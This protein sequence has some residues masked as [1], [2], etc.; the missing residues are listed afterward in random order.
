MR[1]ACHLCL[2]SVDL[3]IWT[4][5]Q[6]SSPIVA[7]VGAILF[8]STAEFIYGR[9]TRDLILEVLLD[10]SD[11]ASFPFT[12]SRIYYPFYN[13]G[14]ELE[15]LAQMFRDDKGAEVTET[16]APDGIPETGQKAGTSK[17]REEHVRV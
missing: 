11:S 17:Q 5:P 15:I 12:H 16:P 4:Q 1:S 13:L 2:D 3:G 7:G 8:I 14:T 9:T 10:I 6:L